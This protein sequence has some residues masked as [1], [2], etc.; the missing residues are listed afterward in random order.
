[1]GNSHLLLLLFLQYMIRVAAQAVK[2]Q[3]AGSSKWMSAGATRDRIQPF[4]ANGDCMHI[5]LCLPA[6]V[7]VC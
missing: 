5:E 1:M 4:Y 2:V 3:G 7:G 6:D